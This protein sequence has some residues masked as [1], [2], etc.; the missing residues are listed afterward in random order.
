MS[1]MLN[2][3][4]PMLRLTL[5]L[6]R[7]IDRAEIDFCAL[8]GE[9]GAPAGVASLEVGG[10]R[11]LFGKAGSPLNKVLGLGLSGPV[12]DEAL[13]AIERFYSE[14]ASPAQIELCPL[15]YADVPARLCSRGFV[16]QAFETQLARLTGRI[17]IERPDV[18]V[19]LA[20]PDEDDLWMR[21]VA[22]GFGAAEPHA[23]GGPEHETFSTE[24]M[25]EMMRQFQHPDIRR[26]LARVEGM[27]AG[28]GS[29][30]VQDRVLGIAGTSTLPAYRR[31]GVQAAI[32]VQAMEDAAAEAD[33]ATA[34]TAPGSTSQRT[35]ER[36]GFQ[37]LYN[38][39]I[40]VKSFRS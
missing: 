28:G 1:L 26:Y 3:T 36:L 20:Q 37:V 14:R 25:I 32:A 39:A 19:T 38:R 8:A 35:F 17:A 33:I 16:L 18:R 23:G 21:V 29:S 9:V 31:R 12:S 11:A 34:T 4:A 13:D 10:G 6:A 27:P 15:A 7:R 5:E 2:T 22:E 24:Q 30:W 40:V